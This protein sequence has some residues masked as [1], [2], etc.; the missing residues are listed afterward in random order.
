MVCI[1]F[2]VPLTT[3]ALINKSIQAT[4]QVP[5]SLS[6]FARSA[7]LEQGDSLPITAGVTV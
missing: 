3:L 7:W 1:H 6:L 5:A 2:V 4:N